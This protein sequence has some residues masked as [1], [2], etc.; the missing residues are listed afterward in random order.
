MSDEIQAKPIDPAPKLDTAT[1]EKDKLNVSPT[2]TPV[3]GQWIAKIGVIVVI[4]AGAVLALPTAGVALPPI[5]VTI[6]T[7]V[8]TLGGALGIAS[9][10]VRK[11]Q[12]ES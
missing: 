4:L 1:T 7:V 12:G 2:G 6:A 8:A 9:P 5:V 3:L 10:G 11:P